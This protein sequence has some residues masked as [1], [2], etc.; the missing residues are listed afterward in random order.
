[1]EKSDIETSIKEPVGK[2]YHGRNHH[3]NWSR[4][5]GIAVLKSYISIKIYDLIK[6]NTNCIYRNIEINIR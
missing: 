5:T 3:S 2:C 4:L 1:M 6:T